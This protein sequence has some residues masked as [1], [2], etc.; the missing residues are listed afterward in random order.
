[1]AAFRWGV[2]GGASVVLLCALVVLALGGSGS[3][4]GTRV[5]I[6]APL[7][8]GAV[9][10]GLPAHKM[11]AMDLKIITVSAIAFIVSLFISWAVE[12]VLFFSLMT[13][14]DAAERISGFFWSRYITLSLLSV[15][16][17]ALVGASFGRP[18]RF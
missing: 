4:L 11:G 8:G 2:I 15:P 3:E 6:L 5:L 13:S 14:E 7:F 10:A 12:Y 18:A 9:A 16:A 1:M 17:G